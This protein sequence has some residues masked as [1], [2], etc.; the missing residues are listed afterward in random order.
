[1]KQQNLLPNY[2]FSKSPTKISERLTR[3]EKEKEKAKTATG[4]CVMQ[5]LPPKKART[6]CV[7]IAGPSPPQLVQL[8]MVNFNLQS[9]LVKSLV[10][11]EEDGRD[12]PGQQRMIEKGANSQFYAQTIERGKFVMKIYDVT[13]QGPLTK[14]SPAVWTIDIIE[15]VVGLEAL[16]DRA[17]RLMANLPF[18]LLP[19]NDCHFK[20][21]AEQCIQQRTSRKKKRQLP[22]FLCTQWLIFLF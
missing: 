4:I 19:H 21:P 11:R 3:N 20:I 18:F 14:I 16:E 12:S 9:S 2:L 17:Q 10:H 15:K 1:M 8:E 5:N 22:L 7:F 6:G 13:Y